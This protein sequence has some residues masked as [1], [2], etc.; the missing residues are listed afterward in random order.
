MARHFNTT[1]PCNPEKHY[2]LPPERRLHD[3]PR[4]IEQEAYFVLHAPRQTGKTTSLRALAARLTGEGC[5]AAL[6]ASCEAAQAMGSDI[7]AGITVA[8][9]HIEEM[10][11][12]LP[13]ELRPKPLGELSGVEGGSR[14]FVY[15]TRWAERSP[16]PL[17]LLLDEIDAM[18]GA[19]LISALRQLRS[20]YPERPRHFPHSVVLSGLRDVRDYKLTDGL[21]LGTSSPFNIKSE[22]LVL[23]DFTAA[24]VAELY[25]QHTAETGQPFTD[26][27]V[28][29]AFELTRGQPWLV[30]ALA[31]QLV[32]GLVPER[33]APITAGDVERAKEIL[34][35]RRDTHLDSLVDRLREERVR[36]VIAPIL[37][38]ELPVEDV[39]DDDVQFVED[40]GLAAPGPRGLEIAN[41]MYREIVPRALTSVTEKFLPVMRASYVG[42]QGE[43]LFDKLLDDFTVFWI[44]HSEHYLARQPYSEAAAQLIFMAY[45]HKI[46]NGGEIEE[47]MSTVDR[48]YAAG[49]GRIDLLIRWPMP[50]ASLTSREVE[51]FAV[52]LKVWRRGT[53]PLEKGLKQLG[54]YL[55]RL[56]GLDRGT[57]ILFDQRPEAPPPAE[58]AKRDVVERDGRQITVLRL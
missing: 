11:R 46:T 52:E 38:G 23:A 53:D 50:A 12:H 10:A 26:E 1:G 24:E 34:I 4:L 18:V 49:S 19:T 14:L 37:A 15:L 20:G 58:R 51:R 35:R 43:L 57:L 5:Y 31:R 3:F 56:A 39:Y 47:R 17:V 30:N 55:D 6:H 21:V 13:A 54:E 42:E 36:K 33:T 29:L 2:L 8:L 25:G 16:R 45:L 28:A 9:R 7:E 22:S 27:A 32:E 48:E 44:E 41:P 40:L